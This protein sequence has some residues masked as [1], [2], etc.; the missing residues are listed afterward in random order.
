MDRVH[1]KQSSLLSNPVNHAL[2]I[3]FMLRHENAFI[4]L[5]TSSPKNDLNALTTRKKKATP[6]TQTYNKFDSPYSKNTN[7]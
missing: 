3:D 2:D 1:C 7:A 5:Y 6:T 4:D